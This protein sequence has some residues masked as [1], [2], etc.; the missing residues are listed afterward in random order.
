M[1]LEDC[2]IDASFEFPHYAILRNS[3]SLS[4]NGSEAAQGNIE[5]VTGR[6]AGTWIV[7]LLETYR[8]ALQAH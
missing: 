8:N 5:R 3:T 4:G 1:L 2:Y 7:K 6:E